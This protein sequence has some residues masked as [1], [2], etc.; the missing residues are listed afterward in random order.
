L[1]FLDGAVAIAVPSIPFVVGRGIGDLVFGIVRASNVDDLA[2][3]HGLA[4]L[5]G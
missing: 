5:W 3:F 2:F 1:R 4:S